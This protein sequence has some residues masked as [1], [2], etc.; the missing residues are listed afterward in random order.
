MTLRVWPKN[1]SGMQA[2]KREWMRSPVE[3]TSQQHERP[4]FCI[5]TSFLLPMRD[6]PTILYLVLLGRRQVARLLD[7][8]SLVASLVS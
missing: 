2:E 6:E 4:P 3:T 5:A 8:F 1:T 7:L